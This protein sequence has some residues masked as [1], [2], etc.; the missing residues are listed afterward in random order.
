MVISP[1]MLS[2][3]LFFLG[4]VGGDDEEFEG[5]DP[6]DATNFVNAFSTVKAVQRIDMTDMSV[7][8]PAYQF[9]SQVINQIDRLSKE[10]LYRL[11][12]Q[13]GK[14]VTAIK[15]AEAGFAFGQITPTSQT[16]RAIEDPH[17]SGAYAWYWHHI[18]NT[19]TLNSASADSYLDYYINAS[20]SDS[21]LN[22]H[23]ELVKNIYKVL[24]GEKPADLNDATLRNVAKKFDHVGFTQA[25][26]TKISNFVLNNVIGS[27]NVANDVAQSNYYGY[28]AKV[29][30]II[31]ACISSGAYPFYTPVLLE[32]Y[33]MSSYSLDMFSEGSPF[34]TPAKA[35][36]SIVLGAK[37]WLDLSSISMTIELDES[38]TEALELDVY[39][40]YSHNGEVVRGKLTNTVT[41]NPGVYN[42]NSN[43]N[44]VTIEFKPPSAEDFEVEV[45][46]STIPN[47]AIGNEFYEIH[48]LT[49]LRM[50]LFENNTPLLPNMVYSTID[51]SL[52]YK[53]RFEIFEQDGVSN[54][55]YVDNTTS[56]VQIF[57]KF[58][59]QNSDVKF[60]LGFM[61]MK[62]EPV[63]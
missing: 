16:S 7:G 4:G 3:C 1:M 10:I 6:D 31:A 33:A 22:Y 8:S 35:Y 11:C 63:L 19:S 56:F 58:K 14:G 24:V 32:D 13:Y 30:G 60:K 59:G 45:D 12:G 62:I 51:D 61:D 54:I 20:A 52:G 26:Q 38:I 2:G 42:V 36:T 40:K 29:P 41:V 43:S 57:F 15:A 23:Q 55:E 25:E 53:N 47:Y 21:K 48:N 17:N 9:T 50:G 46:L 39:A 49:K 34:N 27:S 18:G 28:S 37:F 5:V 44:D